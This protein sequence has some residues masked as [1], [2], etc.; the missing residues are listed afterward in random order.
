VGPG[1]L[2]QVGKF[3]ALEKGLGKEPLI[4][5]QSVSATAPKPLPSFG[6]ASHRMQAMFT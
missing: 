4:E 3:K 1:E 5:L 2:P 6:K